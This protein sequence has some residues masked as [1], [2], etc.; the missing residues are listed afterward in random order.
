MKH[1]DDAKRISFRTVT[2][3]MQIDGLFVLDNR[4]GEKVIFMKLGNSLGIRLS[5]FF[6]LFGLV[7][8]LLLDL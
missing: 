4:E 3:G 6:R 8:P 2:I 7:N 1:E 5:E